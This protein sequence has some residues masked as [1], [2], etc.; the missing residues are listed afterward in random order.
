MGRNEGGK[1]RMRDRGKEGSEGGREEGERER[2][3]KPVSSS[4]TKSLYRGLH[5]ATRSHLCTQDAPGDC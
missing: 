5:K 3:R 1:E 4:C 2:G